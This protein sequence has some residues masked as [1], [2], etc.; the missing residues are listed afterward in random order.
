MPRE[1]L[2][3][4]QRLSLFPLVIHVPFV[5]SFPFLHWSEYS[6][7]LNSVSALLLRGFAFPQ[8][9]LQRLIGRVER[10]AQALGFQLRQRESVLANQSLIGREAMALGALAD[11]PAT[12]ASGLR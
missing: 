8:R 2:S 10:F 12:H 9:K 1:S 5:R 6:S 4:P 7:V 11:I 3:C